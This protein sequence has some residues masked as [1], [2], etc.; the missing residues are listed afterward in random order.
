MCI[1]SR[2][3]KSVDTKTELHGRR[4]KTLTDVS[5]NNPWPSSQS[6]P[7]D[8][9]AIKKKVC[10]AARL[11]YL[12]NLRDAAISAAA[13]ALRD[14][15]KYDGAVVQ[16]TVT[17]QTAG[18][19]ACH[20]MRDMLSGRPCTVCTAKTCWLFGNWNASCW[21]RVVWPTCLALACRQSCACPVHQLGLHSDTDVD[22]CGTQRFRPSRMPTAT[23][24]ASSSSVRIIIII[25]IFFDPR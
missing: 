3:L 25:I 17:S 18:L 23:L 9:T 14:E 8:S 10:W 15:S 12:A 22:W 7:R 1:K 21:E 16:V 24:T 2:Q 20:R 5:R 13:T 6:G 19:P 11:L 4:L